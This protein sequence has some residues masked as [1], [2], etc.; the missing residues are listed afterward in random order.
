MASAT[1][2]AELVRRKRPEIVLRWMA[3]ARRLPEVADL[4]RDDVLDSVPDVVDELADLL[5]AAGPAIERGEALPLRTPPEHARERLRQGIDLMTVLAEY[6][7]LRRTI[8][9][10]L[11]ATGDDA[12]SEVWR[13]A[14]HEAIDLAIADT[15]R[16]YTAEATAAQREGQRLLDDLRRSSPLLQQ[17]F[18]ACS[19]GLALLDRNL[20]F[21][22]LNA[23]L[24]ALDGAAAADHFAPD[25]AGRLVREVIPAFAP[26]LEGLLLRVLDGGEAIVDGEV[27]GDPGGGGDP[28]RWQATAYLVSSADGSPLGSGLAILDVTERRRAEDDRARLI[29]EL[30]G[31]LAAREE[32]LA[33]AAHEISAPLSALL[34]NIEGA[35]HWHERSGWGRREVCDSL[36]AAERQTRRL[37]LLVGSLLDVTRIDRGTFEIVRAD[38]DLAALAR[39]IAGRL[40]EAALQAG[41]AL[42]VRAEGPV[43]GRWDRLRLEQVV[44]NLLTN[45]LKY[46]RGRPV[47]VTVERAPEGLARLRVRDEGI[48]IAPEDRERIFERYERAVRGERRYAGL[49]LG[50]WIARRI[51]EA[52]GGSIGVESTPGAG[53]T[54]TVVV[55]IG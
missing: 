36:V 35:V 38:V 47:E 28:R 9:M 4:A 53:S 40:G 26:G 7:L 50:L 19:V 20:R 41:C 37:S 22:H 44:T 2:V 3:A 11:D 25:G 5:E 6:A 27:T 24:C 13:R 34:L 43:I 54:F 31:S 17:W 29:R 55:P 52:L 14:I 32:L 21:L 39:D 10:V 1:S 23:A 46:G 12:P 48:G 45:A 49:G 8:F 16:A 42:T 15:A 18:Q 33:V 51:V 30:E